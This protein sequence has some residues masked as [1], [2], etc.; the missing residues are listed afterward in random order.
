MKDFLCHFNLMCN[1][2]QVIQLITCSVFLAIKCMK[3]I[4]IGSTDSEAETPILWPP[5]VKNWLIGKD[6]DPG[7]D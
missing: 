7:K 4:F 1:H 5:D 3:T 2:T 6:P